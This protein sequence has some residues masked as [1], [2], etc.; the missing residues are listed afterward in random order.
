MEIVLG[1]MLLGVVILLLRAEAD[2]NYYRWKA[3]H[4]EIEER[5]R[6]R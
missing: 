1:L 2:A 6:G 4:P 3:Q 5:R